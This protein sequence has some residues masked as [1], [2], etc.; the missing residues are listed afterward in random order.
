MENFEEA[1]RQST[2][3]KAPGLDGINTELW[4]HGSRK[5]KIRLL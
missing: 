5:L 4:K 2:N 1:L 3:R